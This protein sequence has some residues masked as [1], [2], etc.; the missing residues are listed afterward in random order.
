MSA[1]DCPC[2]LCRPWQ[3]SIRSM[4]PWSL[5]HAWEVWG[6]GIL[7]V[8]RSGGLQARWCGCGCGSPLLASQHLALAVDGPSEGA[9]PR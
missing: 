3:H 1:D 7:E 5:A 4:H 9:I 8:W 6:S 2:L